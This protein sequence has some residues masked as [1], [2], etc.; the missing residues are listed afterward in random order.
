[1][2]G[3]QKRKRHKGFCLVSGK[4]EPLALLHEPAI[5]GIP[6]AQVSGAKIVSFNCASFTSYGKEQSLN[7]P[8]GENTAFL[9]QCP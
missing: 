3:Q 9:L 8:V 6:G 1:M 4:E 5:K 7:A 2:A